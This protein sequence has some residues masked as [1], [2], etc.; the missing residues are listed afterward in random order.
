MPASFW[1]GSIEGATP[2]NGL[3]GKPEAA[4]KQPA[5]VDPGFVTCHPPRS[6]SSLGGTFGWP[7]CLGVASVPA[8]SP[9]ASLFDLK[10]RGPGVP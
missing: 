2:R 7:D 9:G 8:E 4:V 6:M 5:P 3:L 10:V 1:T